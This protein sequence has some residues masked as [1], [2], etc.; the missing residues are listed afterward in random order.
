MRGLP[1]CL[2]SLLLLLL[3]LSATGWRH[4]PDTNHYYDY[5]PIGKARRSRSFDLDAYG[6]Q[7]R[8]YDFDQAPDDE[9][10]QT[11]QPKSCTMRSSTLLVFGLL[12]VLLTVATS[13]LRHSRHRSDYKFYYPED[14]RN[15]NEQLRKNNEQ[16]GRGSVHHFAQQPRRNSVDYHKDYIKNHYGSAGSHEVEQKLLNDRIKKGKKYN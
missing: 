8:Y 2:F 13:G 3:A 10:I 5:Y 11:S 7:G 14:I 9:S 16:Q 12:L 4:H 15:K 1:L 6:T